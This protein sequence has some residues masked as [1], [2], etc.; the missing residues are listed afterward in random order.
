MSEYRPDAPGADVNNKAETEPA[1]TAA[2]LRYDGNSAPKLVAKGEG[3]L[4][5]RIIALAR[6]YGVHL[7]EDPVLARALMQMQLNQEIPRNLYV[8]IA[9]VI[10]FAYYLQGKT[11]TARG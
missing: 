2:A 3:E 5:E 8:A 11:P 1:K 10:A 7:H 6:E 9:R 4:A